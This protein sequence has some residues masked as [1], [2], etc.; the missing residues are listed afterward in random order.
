MR[1]KYHW[2][3]ITKYEIHSYNS[4]EIIN[5]N[6]LLDNTEFLANIHNINMSLYGVKKISWQKGESWS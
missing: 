6:N 2:R 4:L 3:N 1:K 5:L